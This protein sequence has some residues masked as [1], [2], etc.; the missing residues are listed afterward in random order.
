[1]PRMEQPACW[2]CSSRGWLVIAETI[3]ATPPA[4]STASLVSSSA[5]PSDAQLSEYLDHA[6]S[7]DKIRH[8]VQT[9][10]AQTASLD[11]PQAAGGSDE[12]R[13]VDRIEDGSQGLQESMVSSMLRADLV[14]LMRQHLTDA[15]REV[16]T[17]R[18]GLEDGTTRTVRSVGE[19]LGISYAQT[20]SVLF[21]ALTKLRRPHVTLAIKDYRNIDFDE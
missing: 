14:R 16:V 10:Q 8:I 5:E 2:T 18:F 19:E 15:E 13:L 4:P 1:M 17:L 6:L 7:P 12:R 11:A 9:V 21:S 20:K 3:S